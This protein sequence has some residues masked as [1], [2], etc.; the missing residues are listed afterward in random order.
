M[1]VNFWGTIRENNWAGVL[2]GICWKKKHELFF[3]GVFRR[4]DPFKIAVKFLVGNE[5]DGT[6]GSSELLL[7]L[8]MV[9]K[10]TLWLLR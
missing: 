3:I 1:R 10:N 7:I 2:L 4:D 8:V 9:L 6:G 5:F